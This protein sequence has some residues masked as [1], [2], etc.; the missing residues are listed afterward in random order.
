MNIP[1]I[2]LNY[3]SSS[4]CRKCI[5]FLKRQEGVEV[6][7]I[8]VD[9]CSPREGEQEAVQ[10]FCQEQDCTFIVAEENRGNKDGT[11]IG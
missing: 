3:N 10:Q 2:L 5:S 11:N 4:D 9:N 7:I 1:V 8:V 6:D